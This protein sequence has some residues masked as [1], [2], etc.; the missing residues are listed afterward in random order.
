VSAH[1]REQE[2]ARSDV[3]DVVP[4][5]DLEDDEVL[6]VE[7]AGVSTRAGVELRLG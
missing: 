2:Q 6:A 7:G 3:D 4:A 5:V 1:Q